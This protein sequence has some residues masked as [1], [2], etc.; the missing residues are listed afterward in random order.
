MDDN[1][2]L[3]HFESPWHRGELATATHRQSTRNPT[4]G[5]EVTLQLRVN[6]GT[7]EEAWFQASGCMVSQASASMLC[8]HI[9]GCGLQQLSEFNALSMLKLIRVPLSPKRQQCGLLPFKA[10]KTLVYSLV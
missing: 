4:C 3:D 2:I 1:P 7:L 8:Q 9:E 5:D 6:D 10:L